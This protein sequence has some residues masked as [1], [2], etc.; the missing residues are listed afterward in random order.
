MIVCKLCHTCNTHPAN[1]VEGDWNENCWEV[2]KLKFPGVEATS[3]LVTALL[4]LE[5]LEEFGGEKQFLGTANSWLS[6]MVDVP[7]SPFEWE[8]NY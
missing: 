2:S 3:S 8:N 1:V 6:L 5:L 7:L 4:L